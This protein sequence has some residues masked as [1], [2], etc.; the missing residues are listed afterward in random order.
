MH[1]G[2]YTATQD[3]FGATS[4]G[5]SLVL[6]QWVQILLFANVKF[7]SANYKRATYVILKGANTFKAYSFI[8]T[9]CNNTQLTRRSLLLSS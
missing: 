6:A 5:T 8:K 3:I 2:K 4:F 9:T 1:K 7:K